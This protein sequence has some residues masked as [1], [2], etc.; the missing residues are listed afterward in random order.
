MKVLFLAFLLAL[1][2]CAT[3]QTM[4][5]TPQQLFTQA[6]DTPAA[7]APLAAGGKYKFKGPVSIVVQTGT[8]NVATPTVK[9]MDQTGQHAQA[10]STG[11][12]S[13]VAATSKKGGVP[14][15]VFVGVGGLSIAAWQWLKSRWF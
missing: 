7:L 4:L 2:S 11:S 8:G 13:P 3:E 10:M 5:T 15:W 9:G 6:T 14:W 1:A 12:G